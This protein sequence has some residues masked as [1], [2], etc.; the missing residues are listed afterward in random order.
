MCLFFAPPASEVRLFFY[1]ELA[2]TQIKEG[3]S[4]DRPTDRPTGR[5]TNELKKNEGAAVKKRATVCSMP[6]RYV[7]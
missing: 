3:G 2:S 5:P 4:F 7:S 1:L 6:L